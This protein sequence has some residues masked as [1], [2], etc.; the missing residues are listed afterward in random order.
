MKRVG[1]WLGGSKLHSAS[2]Q[3]LNALD[4]PQALEAAMAA[5]IH[6]LN[7]D[8]ETADTEL[9]KGNSPF[10]KLGKG[11]VAFL[12][13]TLGFEREVMQQASNMLAESEAAASEHQKHAHR[14]AYQSAIYPP[15]SEYALCQA[16]SQLMGAVVA[17]LSESLTESLKGFY[18]LRK[19]YVALQEIS[20]AERRFLASRSATSMKNTSMTGSKQSLVSSSSTLGG[21]TLAPTTADPEPARFPA[22]APAEDDDLEF[23]D[24]DEDV[25]LATPREYQ[26]HLETDQ[27]SSKVGGLSVNPGKVDQTSPESKA[28]RMSLTSEDGSEFDE[29][30]KHPV[31][32]F[33]H[34]GTNLCFGILL[35]LLSLIPPAFSKLL[36]VV[37]FKGD[38][39][40]GLTLLW[41]AIKHSDIN[42][43]NGAIA[44]LVTLGYYGAMV[45][46]AD[47]V[48]QS[49]YPKL[50]L[51]ELLLKMRATYPKSR[52]WLLEEAR[53]L[54]GDKKLEEALE[55]ADP[56]KTKS[57]LKQ[58]EALQWFERSLNCM[59]LHDYQACAD[60]FLKC[61]TLNNWSHGLYYYIA[62]VCHVELY[63]KHKASDSTRAMKHAKEATELLRGVPSRAGK[64]R[65]MAKQLPFDAFV[66]RKIQ[67]WEERAIEWKVDL[68]DAVGVA[69]V[70]EMIYFWNGYKRM[71]PEHLEESLQILAWNEDTNI[72]PTWTKQAFD[73]KAILRFLRAVTISRLGKVRESKELLQKEVLLHDWSEF[74]GHLKDN[75]TLPVA[76][77]EMAVNIWVDCGGEKGSHTALQECSTWLEKCARWET[78][79]LDARVGLK[80]TTA[81]DTLGKCGIVAPP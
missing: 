46:F 67:K 36:Y 19:A 31:D 68:I 52:L 21:S 27:L 44:G 53:M 72:N 3:S 58:V 74:K 9:S 79:D 73:E 71:R 49:S 80:V 42:G 16:E 50:K 35:L 69:P 77:Y 56:R 24:A 45:G 63:R 8:V 26:G 29:L 40:R 62:G 76:H 60:S 25:G 66:T 57:P 30:T 48:A 10:H 61:V 12:R 38:R 5:V 28:E 32:L 54:A 6:I 17:V 33:I 14:D 64:K 39:D 41:R 37:G 75:W 70:E 47:I 2:T 59:Y 13:A 78:Y 22:T 1:G 34:C 55:L 81:R 18:R 7:D 51:R 20:D 15:G 11:V 4:E 43:I 65:L 23:V